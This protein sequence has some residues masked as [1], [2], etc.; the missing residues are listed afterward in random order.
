MSTPLV[1]IVC[2]TYNHVK[3]IRNTLDGFLMQDTPFPCEILIH[4]DASTDG[5]D[6]I[7]REYADR[8][9]ER[10]SPLFETEN[11][12]SRG[13]DVLAEV[14]SKCQGRYYAICEGDD[15]WID[16]NKLRV[17]VEYM[18]AHPDCMMTLHN[19]L[20]F[21]YDTY[22]FN[23]YGHV[24]NDHDLSPAEVIKS[25]YATASMVFRPE[26]V[27]PQG[28]FYGAGKIG[29]WP[30]RLHVLAQGKK[31]HYFN[32]TMC[33]YRAMTPHSFCR[34][35]YGAFVPAIKHVWELID[36]ME[37][38][39]IAT[40]RKFEK[41]IITRVQN[42]VYDLFRIA[43]TK[44]KDEFVALLEHC[45]KDFL[46]IHKE[47]YLAKV[48]RIFVQVYD[49]NPP[50]AAIIENNMYKFRHIVIYGAGNFGKK[51]AR[52]LEAAGC[53][54][55]GFVVSDGKECANTVMKKPVWNLSWVP[56]LQDEV[57]VIVAIAPRIWD[58]LFDNLMERGFVHIVCPF[59]Y[60]I[61]RLD[62]K[63]GV[64]E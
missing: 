45:G 6:D 62:G 12:F 46:H 23:L 17:Q 39:N 50:L 34:R 29:D 1:S 32:R 60:D 44:N 52:S 5:T 41:Y 63:E 58:E 10:I 19:A 21:N 25:G 16:P 14:Y 49:K 61:R 53:H 8:Y 18:E 38:Y 27:F 26:A 15:F 40:E 37:Q 57:L 2:I 51:I 43:E 4:D 56:F 30:L 59:L 48:K 7:I 22:R 3:Y 31:I 11:Q 20:V 35:T 28:S 42:S 55:D 36:L 64:I 47:G 13:V 33:V 9:P 24:E 54:Y